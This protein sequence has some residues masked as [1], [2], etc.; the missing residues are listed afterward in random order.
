MKNLRLLVAVCV[1]AFGLVVVGGALAGN[2]KVLILDSTVGGGSS[3]LEAQAA[4]AAGVWA[5]TLLTGRRGMR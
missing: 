2:G 5:W 4:V 3:S 1:A